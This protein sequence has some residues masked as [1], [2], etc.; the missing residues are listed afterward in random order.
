MPFVYIRTHLPNLQNICPFSPYCYYVL[1]L[2]QQAGMRLEEMYR[3]A[4]SSF[5]IALLYIYIYMGIHKQSNECDWVHR[6][7]QKQKSYMHISTFYIRSTSKSIYLCT[8]SITSADFHFYIIESAFRPIYM[9]NMIRVLDRM[10]QIFFSIHC[11]YLLLTNLIL[12]QI[13]LL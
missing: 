9:M 2:G 5:C 7:D 12:W 11:K 1:T 10:L 8:Y 13:G 4:N 6:Q 3:T